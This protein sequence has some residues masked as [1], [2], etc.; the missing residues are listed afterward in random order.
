MAVTHPAEK[1]ELTS[2]AQSRWGDRE[3]SNRF[4][5]SRNAGFKEQ[6]VSLKSIYKECVGN[7]IKG[8]NS[9]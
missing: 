6:S 9:R 3:K 8:M 4:H 1:R 7:T 2:L 5:N